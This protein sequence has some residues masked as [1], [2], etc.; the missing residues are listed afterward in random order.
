M[1]VTRNERGIN[2][3]RERNGVRQ[4]GDVEIDFDGKVNR[5]RSRILNAEEITLAGNQWRCAIGCQ[6]DTVGRHHTR[7]QSNISGKASAG[8]SIL[9][10]DQVEWS[11]GI[12]KSVGG[13]HRPDRHVHEEIVGGIGD[14]G[15]GH[16]NGVEQRNGDRS[17]ILEYQVQTPIQKSADRA[18]AIVQ[19]F[20]FPIAGRGFALQ[21][22]Q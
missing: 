16:R 21:D 6:R 12:E 18:G 10:E 2:V 20:Q 15:I 8:Q 4:R 19:D 17:D 9:I 11:G 5:S 22:L 13:E 7:K 3:A 1:E 14:N